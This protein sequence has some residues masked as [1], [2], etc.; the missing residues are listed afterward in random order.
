MARRALI[1]V[2]GHRSVGLLYVKAAQRLGLHPITL[3][4]DYLAAE[5]IEAIR[6]DTENLDA[7]VRECSRLRATYDI[8]GITGFTDLDDS[9]YATVG[10]LCRYFDLPGPNPAS[11][12]R[13]CDKFTQRQLLAAAGVPMPACRLAANA[14][15]VE[16]CNAEIGLPVVLKP[17]VGSGSSDVRLCRNVDELSEQTTYLLDGKHIACLTQDTD[18]QERRLPRLSRIYHRLPS[19]AGAELILQHAVAL[20]A[21]SIIPFSALGETEQSAAPEGAMF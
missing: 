11:I 18:R 2:E 20:I 14:T 9:A 4:A 13:C 6:V 5:N 3:S 8:A 10:K 7:L 19:R 21:W 16:S 1:L 17:P 12:E 15:D